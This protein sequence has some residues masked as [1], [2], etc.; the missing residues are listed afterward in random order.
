MEDEL[1]KGESKAPVN[2]LW[3]SIY[4]LGSAA[5]VAY[6]IVAVSLNQWFQ[7]CYWQFG[8][9]HADT[10]LKNSAFKSEDT[11]SDVRADSCYGLKQTVES[12]CP[13]F[14]DFPTYFEF[15]GFFI[16]TFTILG[17]ICQ[18]FALFYHV[19]RFRRESV[20]VRFIVLLQGA[21]FVLEFV[22]FIGYYSIGRFY[23]IEST[24]DL[25]IQNDRPKDFEWM[26][27]MPIFVSVFVLQLGLMVLGIMK[28]RKTFI[29]DTG[30]L[31]GKEF[32]GAE[33]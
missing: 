28:T 25:E 14:C 19:L 16:L 12:E 30:E 2:K 24:K 13:K 6:T 33:E 32:K 22:G 18:I 26:G 27:G 20:R 23:A 21:P 17:I 11:I 4:M 7:Y 5:L 8:L 3:F 10:F 1:V 29:A 15:A 9:I 31:E